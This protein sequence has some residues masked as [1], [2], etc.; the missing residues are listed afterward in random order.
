MGRVAAMECADLRPR[1]IDLDPTS[2]PRVAAN[3]LVGELE[4]DGDE[5]QVAYRGGTRFVA[6]LARV[7]KEAEQ[8]SVGDGSSIDVHADTPYQLRISAAGSFDGLRFVPCS[9]KVPETGQVELEIRATGQHQ[10]QHWQTTLG[11][12]RLLLFCYSLH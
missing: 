12:Q 1:L 6:R 2:E 8:I 9:R 3:D 10:T 4:I 11:Q 7:D 5:A